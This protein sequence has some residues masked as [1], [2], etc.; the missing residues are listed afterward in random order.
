MIFEIEI[1]LRVVGVIYPLLEEVIQ[2]FSRHIFTHLLK[3]FRS[4][5]GI[6]EISIR[7]VIINTI[8]EYAVTQHPPKHMQYISPFPVNNTLEYVESI[9]GILHIQCSSI[10]ILITTHIIQIRFITIYRLI[11]NSFRISCKAFIQPGMV[12]VFTG[13]HISKPHMAQLVY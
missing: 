13:D 9:A 12:P 11:I 2:V 6:H 1:I 7:R 5:L 10:P 3:I 4:R 8:P